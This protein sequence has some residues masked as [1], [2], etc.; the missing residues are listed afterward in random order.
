MGAT[1]TFG[2]PFPELADPANGPAAFQAGLQG[3]ENTV[4]DT[5]LTDYVPA[6]TSTGATQPGGTITKLGKYRIDNGRC[7]IW[8]SFVAGAG[9][10][11]GTGNLYVALPIAPRA[12]MWQ[13]VMPAWFWSPS[14]GGG[15]YMGLAR[16]YAGQLPMPIYLPL[17]PSDTRLSQWRNAADGNATGTGIPVVAGGWA[18]TTGSEF[19]V[20]GSSFV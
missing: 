4:K 20:C 12:D 19:L 15:V 11:G 9:V 14:S 2:W 17:G 16:A 1:T 8:I 7:T 18:M 10:N 6:W 5:T 13:Q 3:A